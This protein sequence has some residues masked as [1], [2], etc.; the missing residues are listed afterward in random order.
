MLSIQG[1]TLLQAGLT[2]RGPAQLL[3]HTASG[4]QLLWVQAPVGEPVFSISFPGA[5]GDDLGGAHVLE[6]LIFRGA[7]HFPADP[8]YPALTAG[9][10]ISFLNAS[11]R[12]G[13]T[14]FHAAAPTEAALTRVAEVL[15]EAVFHPLLTPEA[16]DAEAWSLPPGASAPQGVILSEMRDYLAQPQAALALALRRAVLNG[17]PEAHNQSGNPA[18]LPQLTLAATRAL[19]GQIFTPGNAFLTLTGAGDF[20]ALLALINKAL[21]PGPGRLPPLTT[22]ARPLPRLDLPHP[23]DGL[24][25]LAWLLP[26]GLPLA[27]LLL[28]ESLLYL[29][30]DPALLRVPGALRGPASGLQADTAQPFMTLALREGAAAPNLRHLAR[31]LTAEDLR[32]AARQA[33]QIWYDDEV[34]PRRPTGLRITDPLLP[35]WLAGGDPFEALN[36]GSDLR[37]L[38]AAPEQTLRHLQDLLESLAATPSLCAEVHLTA[39]AA[40]E[41]PAPLALPLHPAPLVPLKIHSAES[42]IPDLPRYP[43]LQIPGDRLARLRL[44][45]CVDPQDTDSLAALA[46]TL[47]A[48]LRRDPQISA[49]APGISVAPLAGVYGAALVLAAASLPEDFEALCENLAQALKAPD[50]TAAPLPDLRG[51]M[52]QRPQAVI[53]LRL[54]ARLSTPAFWADRMAG[55]GRLLAPPPGDLPEVWHRLRQRG[56]ALVTAGGDEAAAQALRQALALETARPMPLPAPQTLPKGDG[57]AVNSAFHAV[58]LGFTAPQPAPARA[59]LRAIEAEYLWPQI[60]TAG[61]AYGLR[62][63]SEASGQSVIFS[64]RDPHLLRSLQVMREAGA[65][66]RGAADAAMMQRSKRGAAG[67][68]LTPA[69]PQMVL[70]NALAKALGDADVDAMAQAELQTL[71]EMDL[72]DFR[73]AAEALDAALHSAAP[74]VFGPEASLRAALDEVPGLFTLHSDR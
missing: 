52:A 12:P 26:K 63:E 45:L 60:R 71:R 47:Q 51:L 4:A 43:D 54:R 7:R 58:G 32:R 62:I 42:D 28:L 59:A 37:A 35:R 15:L 72:A 40:P 55:P 8:L 17:L 50:L 65:W 13:Y 38:A 53:G 3:R 21:P 67:Q 61:G 16:F 39:A 41:F 70:Q 5:S 49:L 10:M 9:E 1:F 22:Q 64:A 20:S 24:W 48:G 31:S 36:T 57:F 11:A 69:T 6:H 66:L 27:E 74:V 30:P 44:A 56:G 14:T 46:A 18:L 25:G 68:I 33:L 34:F 29:G 23:S 2:D 73:A 19:H